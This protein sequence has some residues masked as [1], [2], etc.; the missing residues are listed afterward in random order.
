MT[1]PT[2]RRPRVPAGARPLFLGDGPSETL[3]GM[4]L[5]L[6]TEVS[7]L[8]DEM[9]DLREELRACRGEVASEPAA[10]DARRSARRRAMIE[11]M[12]RIVDEELGSAGHAQRNAAYREFVEQ[13]S[14]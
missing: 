4:L 7:A 10:V 14:R 1:D 3:L 8:A 5:A 6:A 2:P 11:R 9:D 13:L 12:L